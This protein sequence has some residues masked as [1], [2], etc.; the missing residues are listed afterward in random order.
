MSELLAH[1]RG[2][3]AASVF[4]LI[5]TIQRLRG[6]PLHVL[7][8]DDL[9]PGVFGVWRSYPERDEIHYAPWVAAVDRTVAHEF[10]HMLLGHKG[11][12]AMETA[13]RTLPPEWHDMASLMLRECGQLDGLDEPLR[14]LEV[15]AEAFASELCRRIAGAGGAPSARIRSLLNEAL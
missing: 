15:E 10:G 12:S 1:V 3:E 2:Q 14:R 8:N 5:P 4:G 6:R 7:C 13:T 11:V 9:A